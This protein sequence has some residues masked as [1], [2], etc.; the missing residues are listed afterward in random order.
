MTFNGI[1]KSYEICDSYTFKQIEVTT[2]KPTYLGFAVLELSK[3]P[4]YETYYDKLQPNFGYQKFQIHYMDLHSF[5]LTV[6]TKD[7]IKNT[8]NLRTYL[9]SAI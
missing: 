7:I 2:E 5:I 8:K 9:I 1:H 6:N 3:L 4:M